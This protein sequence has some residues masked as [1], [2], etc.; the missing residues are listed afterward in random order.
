[1]IVHRGTGEGQ[2]DGRECGVLQELVEPGFHGRDLLV[3]PGAPVLRALRFSFA[4]TLPRSPT[5]VNGTKGPVSY[6][7][8]SCLSQVSTLGIATSTMTHHERAPDWERNNTPIECINL[9]WFPCAGPYSHLRRLARVWKLCHADSPT[10]LS[11]L[12]GRP[13]FG[14]AVPRVE[15]LSQQPLRGEESAQELITPFL[16][17]PKM[18][19]ICS[20]RNHCAHINPNGFSHL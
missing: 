7:R 6:P 4:A 18:P 10:E 5:A 17:V 11:P 2:H 19:A 14:W 16:P 1:M 8:N 15:T 13:V 3:R 9:D 12:S 20:R